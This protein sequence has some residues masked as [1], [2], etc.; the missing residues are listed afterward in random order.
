MKLRLAVVVLAAVWSPSPALAT[1]HGPVY[2]LATP[3]L[4]KG[5]WSL[6]VAVMDREVGGRSMNMLRPMIAYGIT[7]DLQVSLSLPMPL[8]VPPG[9]PHGRSMAMMPSNPDVEAL[10]GWR[11]HRSG[12]G[13]GARFEST[14]YLG[15]DYPTDELRGGARTS[16]GLYGAAVT[17]YASRKVYAWVGGLYRRYMTPASERAD[18]PGD[19]AMYSAVLGYRPAFF[20]KDYPHADWRV[21]V[22]LVGEYAK[23]DRIAGADVPKTGGHQVFIAPTLLGLYGKWGISGGPAF[24]VYSDLNGNQPKDK[25]RLVVN[26]TRWF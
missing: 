24:R 16:P 1:G 18:H 4:G 6:D 22:E 13:V 19:L 10:L 15:F 7:E 8:H 9:L 23:P 3:T 2:G 17:G 5:G 14:A 25:V 21:F 26:F 20:R 12:T 11:F